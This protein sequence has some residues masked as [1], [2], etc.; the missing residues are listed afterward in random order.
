MI[1]R[2]HVFLLGEISA[3]KRM[4]KSK[5]YLERLV[6]AR[7]EP[8][9]GPLLPETQAGFCRGKCTSDQIINLTDDN[10]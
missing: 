7:L 6:L 1:R 2:V 10:G 4:A 9:I 8:L 5:C 3:S